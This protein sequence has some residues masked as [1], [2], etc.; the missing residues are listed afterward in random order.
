MTA[1]QRSTDSLSELD[2]ATL[3]QT[4]QIGFGRDTCLLS[5][6]VCVS[7]PLPCAPLDRLR[8]GILGKGTTGVYSASRHDGSL[9]S[10]GFARPTTTLG[11]SSASAPNTCCPAEEQRVKHHRTRG[12]NFHGEIIQGLPARSVCAGADSGVRS[13]TLR[14]ASEAFCTAAC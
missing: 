9:Y 14:E 3:S 4:A 8:G 11:G 5:A 10:R 13:R 1:P 12:A 6:E 7:A 2:P